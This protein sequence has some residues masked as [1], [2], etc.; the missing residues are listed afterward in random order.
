MF[1]VLFL[2]AMDF[3]TPRGHSLRVSPRPWWSAPRWCRWQWLQSKTARW[4]DTPWAD[5]RGGRV[6]QG[7]LKSQGFGKV[8]AAKMEVEVAKLPRGQAKYPII[9]IMQVPCRCIGFDGINK[10]IYQTITVVHQLCFGHARNERMPCSRLLTLQLRETEINQKKI[11]SKRK[12]WVAL[13]F[14]SFTWLHF[15]NCRPTNHIEYASPS[16]KN[17]SHIWSYKII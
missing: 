5:Q 6:V 9:K 17:H 14:N 11:A 10:N 12:G 8:Q 1:C 2:L 13:R 4:S 15:P 3:S 16:V 7:L